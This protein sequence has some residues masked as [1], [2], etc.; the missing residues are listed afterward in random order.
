[1]REYANELEFFSKKSID[2]RLIKVK[3]IEDTYLLQQCIEI[4]WIYKFLDGLDI[5]YRLIWSQILRKESFR[6]IE[7]ILVIMNEESQRTL[8]MEPH[9]VYNSTFGLYIRK[10]KSYL[11]SI[12]EL[13]RVTKSIFYSVPIII[14]FNTWKID[15]SS[16]TRD[17]QQEPKFIS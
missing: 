7:V 3:D 13:R 1:M 11:N 15:A 10:T 2:I 12:I 16:Y 9:R 17:L 6:L 8:V 14:K 5:E 4:D